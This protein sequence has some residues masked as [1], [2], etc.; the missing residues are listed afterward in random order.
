MA[1]ELRLIEIHAIC[2]RRTALF[3][4]VAESHV[5]AAGGLTFEGVPY[6]KDEGFVFNWGRSADGG[7]GK[8]PRYGV[9]K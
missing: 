4:R 1:L 9:G 6:P 8:A 7:F 5:Y 3:S 2:W